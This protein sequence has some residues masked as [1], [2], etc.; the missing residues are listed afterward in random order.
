MDTNQILGS[1]NLAWIKISPLVINLLSVLVL[2]LIGYLVARAL[3]MAVAYIGRLIMLDQLSDKSGLKALLEKG[4]I[5]KPLSDLLGDLVY[6]VMLFI[7]I[8]GITEFFRLPIDPAL[9][10][11]FS[12]IAVIFV[13]AIIL[14]MGAFFASLIA[15]VVR[16]VAGNFG[17]EGAKT[18]SRVI[19]YIVIVFAFLATLAQLGI[20]TEVFIPQIGVIIGAFGLAAAIAFGLGCKDMAADFLYNL[21]KGK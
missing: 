17:I 10:K 14:G 4:D 3:G 1:L 7:S 15:G 2:L 5:K 21:F 12:F 19:Y 16:L 18:I 8:I 11:V 9:E 20:G 6:W 13:A